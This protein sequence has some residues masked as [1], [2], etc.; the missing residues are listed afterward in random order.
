MTENSAKYNLVEE[1]AEAGRKITGDSV[2][3][4]QIPR[5][6][7]KTFTCSLVLFLLG[8]VLLILGI[9][10]SVDENDFFSGLTF[11]MLSIIVLIPGAFYMYQFFKAKREQDVNIRREILDDIPGV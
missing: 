2:T 9:I 8:I 7:R 1:E 6:L 10:K 4:N 3:N 5:R 11:L